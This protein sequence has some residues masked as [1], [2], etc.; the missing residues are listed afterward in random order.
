MS[1]ESRMLTLH[2]LAS[3]FVVKDADV[4]AWVR[5]GAPCVSIN[6]IPPAKRGAVLRFDPA[7]VKRWHESFTKPAC[8]LQQFD[9]DFR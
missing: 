9:F 5:Q 4:R 1:E 2:E 8:I 3:Y 7:A 6:H